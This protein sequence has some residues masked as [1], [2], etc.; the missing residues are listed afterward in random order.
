MNFTSKK[1]GD[2]EYEFH[3]PGGRK[4]LQPLSMRDKRTLCH[5]ARQSILLKIA[6]ASNKQTPST[7][8]FAKSFAVPSLGKSFGPKLTEA[9]ITNEFADLVPRP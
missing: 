4:S 3:G 6:M 2:S 5:H 9:G 1:E 7:G 8:R